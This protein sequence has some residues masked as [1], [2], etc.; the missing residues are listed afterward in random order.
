MNIIDLLFLQ[1]YNIWLKGCRQDTP[2]CLDVI[3]MYRLFHSVHVDYQ[4]CKVSPMEKL[5][6]KNLLEQRMGYDNL[7][8]W[9]K[10]FT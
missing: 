6:I 7:D 9:I 1:Y 3:F 5:L 8:G 4:I 10:E 2:L